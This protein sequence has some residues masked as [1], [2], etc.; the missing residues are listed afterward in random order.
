MKKEL[1]SYI[2]QTEDLVKDKNIDNSRLESLRINIGFFQHERLVHL[3]V[4]MTFALL[5]VISLGLA[6]SKI[7]FLP[8]FVLFLALEVPYVFH[9]YTLENGVQ[10]LQELYR[11]A[12]T[13]TSLK[14]VTTG[15]ASG[16][17]GNS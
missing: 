16:N 14:T 9:Y 1:K 3:I 7:Y 5:T 17:G 13:K 2:K 10:R 12:D 8:L 6:V 4:T 15:K 11:E